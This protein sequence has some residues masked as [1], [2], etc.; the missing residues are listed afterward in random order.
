MVVKAPHVRVGFWQRHFSAGAV[1]SDSTT[2]SCSAKLS[3][4][5]N[6]M[7]ETSAHRIPGV[8]GSVLVGMWCEKRR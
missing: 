7:D 1:K 4:N 2:Q 3:G 5:E 8:D 6:A